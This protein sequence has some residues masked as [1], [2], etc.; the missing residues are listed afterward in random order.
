MKRFINTSMVCAALSVMY[1]ANP[2]RADNNGARLCVELAQT[3]SSGQPKYNCNIRERKNFLN[4]PH[5]FSDKER[6]IKKCGGGFQAL[7]NSV[8]GRPEL[9][10][11][12]R[13][14]FKDKGFG[15]ED[16]YTDIWVKYDKAKLGDVGIDTCDAFGL[17]KA[18]VSNIAGNKSSVSMTLSIA[19]SKSQLT[20][21]SLGNA[22]AL[23]YP[24]ITATRSVD[25][26]KCNAKLV[27]S[28]SK[29]PLVRVLASSQPL[30][31]STLFFSEQM[32]D[33]LAGLK[34][35]ATADT[36]ADLLLGFLLNGDLAGY[37]PDLTFIANNLHITKTTRMADNEIISVSPLSQD[38]D[39]VLDENSMQIRIPVIVNNRELVSL[40]VYQRPDISRIGGLAGEESFDEAADKKILVDDDGKLEAKT[41]REVLSPNS[42]NYRYIVSDTVR[43]DVA[44][45]E[46]AC[47]NVGKALGDR[48]H[49]SDEAKLQMKALLLADFKPPSTMKKPANQDICIHQNDRAKYGK[50]LQDTIIGNGD[51][52]VFRDTLETCMTVARQG[53]RTITTKIADAANAEIANIRRGKSDGKIEI[54]EGTAFGEL[55]GTPSDPQAAISRMNRNRFCQFYAQDPESGNH[56]TQC[57]FAYRGTLT[58]ANGGDVWIGVDAEGKPN[59]IPDIVAITVGAHLPDWIQRSA[60]DS[61]SD[62]CNDYVSLYR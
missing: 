35:T 11:A 38:G 51:D 60:V 39:E 44:T 36:P 54:L 40:T 24:V 57:R 15:Q 49:I 18:F 28:S 58:G 41:I 10:T 20:A 29:A 2:A 25:N 14:N 21:K 37:A 33:P 47:E 31:V 61:A 12:W 8:L 13:D 52:R 9:N 5:A 46:R 30:Y 34:S 50:M 3:Y 27:T 19:V 4:L 23:I 48:F 7:S 59:S 6:C 26:D 1:F 45:L 55:P 32:Q 43:T 42:S 17:T 16:V 62:E 56:N 53:N 22:Q